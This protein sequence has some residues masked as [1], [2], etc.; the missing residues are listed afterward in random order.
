MTTHTTRR[1]ILAGLGLAAATPLGARAQ[2]AAQVTLYTSN[3]AQS[4]EAVREVAERARPP[5]RFSTIT[6][7]SAQLLRRI[8]AEVGRPQADLFWSSSAN[9]M[10]DFRALFAPYRSPELA[11]IPPALHHPDNLFT[12]TNIHLAVLMVNRNQLRGTPAPRSWEDLMA[13]AWRGRLIIAD[14]GNSST[15]YTIL[16]GIEKMMGTDGLRRLATNLRINASAPA[17]LRGVA[18]G[19]FAVGLTFESNAYAY[20]AGGQREIALVYPADGTF[21]TPEFGAVIKDAPAGATAQRAFDILLSRQAQTALLE[22]AFRRPSRSDIDVSRHVD[23]PALG[24]VKVFEVDE[25]EAAAKRA[26]FLAR[27]Q[28]ILQAVG[29]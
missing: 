2:G 23:L 27:W 3:N 21:Q 17:V 18:Q 7:G 13:P 9:T 4:V 22:A 5:V 15:A 29:G 8:A 11:A 12:A 16:W 10:G 26:E 24:S 14:P 20:V 6:G 19:E 25:T 1:T 28:S